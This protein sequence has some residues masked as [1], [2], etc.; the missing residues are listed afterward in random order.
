VKQLLTQDQKTY[1]QDFVEYLKTGNLGGIH[2]GISQQEVLSLV[3]QP[4]WEDADYMV[5]GTNFNI[6]LDNN[7]VTRTT[8]KLYEFPYGGERK[9]CEPILLGA[10]KHLGIDWYPEI[11]NLLTQSQFLRLM[12]RENLALRK[13]KEEE[14]D[15]NEAIFEV[16]Q[17]RVAVTFYKRRIGG[18]YTA[19]KFPADNWEL[20]A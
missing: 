20:W 19:N 8:L 7:I 4:E 1:I 9:W 5:Y 13:Y 2:S 12:A 15:K 16:I 11:A 10:M 3:G 14:I 6:W 17:S 18:I